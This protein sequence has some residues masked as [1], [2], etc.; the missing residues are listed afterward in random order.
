MQK[1]K[2]IQYDF[3]TIN[4]PYYEI[5]QKI[6]ETIFRKYF[7]IDIRNWEENKINTFFKDFS[8]IQYEFFSEEFFSDNS[9]RYNMM[10]YI[11]YDE[12][13]KYDFDRYQIM[14]DYHYA[15]KE[16]IAGNE[17]DCILNM[18][19]NIELE[20]KEKKISYQDKEIILDRFN[21]IY[22]FNGSGKSTLLKSV[23][24]FY[25][26]PIFN[27]SDR[28]LELE[29]SFQN[30]DTFQ[31]MLH[32]F[33]VDHLKNYLSNSEKYFY[34]FSQIVAYCNYHNMPLLLD[35]LS[36]NS[37]DDGN[38]IRLIDALFEYSNSQD[39]VITT[40]NG[41]VKSLV[42]RRVYNPNIINL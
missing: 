4:I 36:W 26:V 12:N 37:L 13:K 34:Q 31:N 3:T 18:N 35:D 42:Q 22:S 29:F 25:Q 16:F 32:K 17:L 2:K 38:K 19:Q 28:N 39:T 23:A 41:D 20:K 9:Y 6:N 11:V 40:C 21:L 1:E 8:S 10:L 7:I 5:A 14:N 33:K 30:D 24:D 15:F 27:M